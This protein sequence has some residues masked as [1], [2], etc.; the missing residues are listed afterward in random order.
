MLEVVVR[1]CPFLVP[2]VLADFSVGLLSPS[3]WSVCLCLRPSTLSGDEILTLQK[4]THISS[5]TFGMC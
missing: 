1:S 5:R 2:A 4:H 3:F